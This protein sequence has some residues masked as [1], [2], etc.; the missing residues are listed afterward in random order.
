[1][2]I[3]AAAPI[4]TALLISTIVLGLVSRTLPQLNIILVGFN[5][6]AL[7]T[8]GALMLSLGGVAWTFQEQTEVVL[9]QLQQVIR[10]AVLPLTPAS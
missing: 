8:L 5:L 3:R 10:P 6:N 7:L 1:M 2:G 9:E 4:L